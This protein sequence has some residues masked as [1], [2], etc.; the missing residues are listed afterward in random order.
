[1]ILAEPS[2]SSPLIATRLV[3]ESPRLALSKELLP[4]TLPRIAHLELL[5]YFQ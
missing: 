3:T 4:G 1:M 5:K 2:P